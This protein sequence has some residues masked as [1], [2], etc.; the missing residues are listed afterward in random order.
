MQYPF[1]FI[2]ADF[3]QNVNR[4]NKQERDQP[5]ISLPVYVLMRC[6]HSHCGSQAQMT[7]RFTYIVLW[8]TSN[9]NRQKDN[10]PIITLMGVGGVMGIS[11]SSIKYINILLHN[12]LTKLKLSCIL[13][14]VSI[15]LLIE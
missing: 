8:Y 1:I 2:I 11:G 4:L 6:A 3:L 9:T 5:V 12:I 15:I 10:T 7:A 14:M 13:K